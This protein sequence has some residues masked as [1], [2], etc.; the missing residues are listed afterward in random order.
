MDDN[1]ATIHFLTS[2]TLGPAQPAKAAPSHVFP[3]M[4]PEASRN[5][6]LVPEPPVRVSA[7]PATR[8][9]ESR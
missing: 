4:R 5:C 6:V 8:P 7:L 9:L 1:R 3:A 2:R